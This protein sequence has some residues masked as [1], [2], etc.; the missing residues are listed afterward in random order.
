[1]TL[2]CD[3]EKRMAKVFSMAKLSK[4]RRRSKKQRPILSQP[5]KQDCMED[6]DNTEKVEDD[7]EEEEDPESDQQSIESQNEEGPCS[8]GPNR[9]GSISMWLTDPQVLHC[10][11][12][13]ETLTIPVFQVFF[14]QYLLRIF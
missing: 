7:H 10:C 11:V 1:M 3:T 6:Y 8:V 2:Y 13:S 14:S 4:S 9:D 12:S 5:A